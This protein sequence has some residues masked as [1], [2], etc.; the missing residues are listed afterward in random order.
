ME[1]GPIGKGQMPTRSCN[2]NG[3][4]LSE[5][6]GAKFASKI[7]S[8]KKKKNVEYLPVI[9]ICKLC[10]LFDLPFYLNEKNKKN[11]KG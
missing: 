11:K 3:Y 4:R 1:K 10:R 5:S 6:R 7:K 2:S 8:N 9:G